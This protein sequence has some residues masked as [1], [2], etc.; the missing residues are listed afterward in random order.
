MPGLS[1]DKSFAAHH[2]AQHWS[3]KNAISP[4]EVSYGSGK[5][6]WFDCD[7]C[8]HDFQSSPNKIT[9]KNRWCQYCANRILCAKDCDV[10]FNKSFASHPRAV[11]W[12]SKNEVTP[13]QIFISSR[14]KRIFN[15]HECNHEFAYSPNKISGGTWC[16][17]CSNQQLCTDNSCT[18]CDNKSFAKHP[19]AES[20]S[21]QNL[22]S[23]RQVFLSS[24]KKRWFNCPQCSHKFDVSPNKI[25]TYDRWCPY[26]S[27]SKLCKADNCTS[28]LNNSFASHPG[29]KH[30]SVRNSKTPRQIFKG[31]ETVVWLVC[32]KKHEFK[33][34]VGEITRGN[35]CSVCNE[36]KGE[37][38]V[39]SCLE[40]HGIEFTKQKKFSGLKH[41][42][43][44]RYD[45]FFEWNGHSCVIEFDG[46]Q[47]FDHDCY[48]AKKGTNFKDTQ[49]RDL[50]KSQYCLDNNINICRIPYTLMR[51]IPKIISKLVRRLS[52]L[53]SD[54][55]SMFYICDDELYANHIRMLKF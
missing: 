19:R 3:D 16:L 31:G 23:A 45:F 13:R 35:W 40:N 34:I 12:S 44:L 46:K 38:M 49:Q 15:C 29:A 1:F 28:C 43:P 32:E 6:Y 33:S 4:K 25:V 55:S 26:C 9:S 47:H 48:F 51:K 20:W 24:C 10:C 22:V 36:S 37:R 41:K 17:Y 42:R 52:V 53:S 14:K 39:T 27:H 54:N 18:T 21:K 8:P 30:W 5:K 50:I 7:K 11:S 2:R